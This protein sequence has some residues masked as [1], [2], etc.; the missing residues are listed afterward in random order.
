MVVP[1]VGPHRVIEDV[2]ADRA[3]EMFGD[4]GPVQEIPGKAFLM[5]HYIIGRFELMAILS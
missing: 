5:K 1:A 4:G 3:V 2:V